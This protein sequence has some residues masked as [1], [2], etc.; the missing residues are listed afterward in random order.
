MSV[1]FLFCVEEDERESAEQAQET[2]E[3]DPS[4]RGNSHEESGD[5]KRKICLPA[6][7]SLSLF[8]FGLRGGWLAAVAGRAGEKTHR[9][10]GRESR[11]CLPREALDAG[12]LF[13]P[14]GFVG[15]GS[16]GGDR[17]KTLPRA[18][19]SS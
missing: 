3:H 11:E 5:E 7:T 16:V 18:H 8:L 4:R 10:A 15:E 6:S 2:S 9:T 17:R 13:S 1:F 14:E 19:T 12:F